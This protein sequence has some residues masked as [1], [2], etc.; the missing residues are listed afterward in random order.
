MWHLC[1]VFIFLGISFPSFMFSFLFYFLHLDGSTQDICANI[2]RQTESHHQN[3]SFLF[4]CWYLIL[5]LKW[6]LK[7]YIYIEGDTNPAI[8]VGLSDSDLCEGKTPQTA[9]ENLILYV[10]YLTSKVLSV[11]GHF[12]NLWCHISATRMWNLFL[13]LLFSVHIFKEE[14]WQV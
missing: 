5:L 10:R 13:C 7:K 8:I 6:W 14:C 11:S 12:V 1:L 4:S 3:L 9:K 2:L